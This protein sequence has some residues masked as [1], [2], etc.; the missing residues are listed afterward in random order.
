MT[1]PIWI[2]HASQLATLALK[3]KGPRVKEAMSELGLIEDG[4]LWLEDGVVKAVGTT[5]EL[6]QQYASRAQEAEVVD[7]SGHLVTPGLVDPHTHVVYGGSREREFEMRLEGSTYM[8]IMNAGG[9]IHATTRMTRE[10]SEKELIEQSAERLNSFLAHGVT[11]VEG[12]SGYGMDLETEL[13]QLRV[14]KKLQKI[15]PIDLVPT[16]MG[17]H[18]V[19]TEYKGREDEFVDVVIEEMLPVVAEEKLAE[20]NDVFCEKDV[21]TPEQSERILEAGKRYGLTPKIHADEIEPYGGAELAAKVGAI[22]A[23]HLLKASKEGI[24]AMA[25]S[26]TIACLLPA[27]ALY[28]REEAAAGRFMIDEGVAVAISTDANP[29]SSPTTSMPLVM[30]LACISMQMT[31]AEALTAATYN[32]ACAI[33]RQG[34]VGSLEVGKLADVVLWDVKNYQELQ[35]LFG[36]NHVK[37]VWKK[38]VQVVVS[39]GEK[40]VSNPGVVLERS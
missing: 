6:E 18:A 29:G 22:S 37:S 11:T 2:K 27:T 4:S 10:A 38:G 17:A 33:N 14:M 23:E 5:V 32:A 13:K 19:P 30:N 1:R 15:H 35:Y 7:A 26:G 20:F 40:V 25:K 31:P 3:G 28:L 39:D 24:R 16:F 8:E 21:Y 12:K 36:V 9:G 34:Q